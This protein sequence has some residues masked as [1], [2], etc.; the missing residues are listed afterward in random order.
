MEGEFPTAVWNLA[1]YLAVFNFHDQEKEIV[2]QIGDFLEDGIEL[3]DVKDDRVFRIEHG[4]L[5]AGIL[6]VHGARLLSK[7]KPEHRG[8]QK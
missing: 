7:V 1:G 5:N 2:V 3:W 6:P 8:N 4:T